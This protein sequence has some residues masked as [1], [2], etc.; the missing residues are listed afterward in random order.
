MFLKI[1]NIIKKT[2]RLLFREL[3]IDGPN[4][5]GHRR[6][7][8]YT[9]HLNARDKKNFWHS[10][11][12]GK[13]NYNKSNDHQNILL[14]AQPKSASLH[15]HAIIADA[16]QITKHEIGFNYY[17]G[18]LYYPR[19][20][21]AKYL[22]CDTISHC[23]AEPTPA[24]VDI[25][26]TLNLKVLVL[27]RNLA[28]TLISRLEMLERDKY[29]SEM[30]SA[31]AIQHFLTASDE[32]KR[33][34]IIDLFAAPYLNFYTGWKSFAAL[35]PSKVLFISYEEMK[36]DTQQLLK[37]VAAWCGKPF[38]CSSE[39]SKESDQK[40]LNFNKGI[41]GRGKM[42][43]SN[44]QKVKILNLA[45]TFELNDEKYIGLSL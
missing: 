7:W 43:F 20:L 2:K 41:I 16:L 32:Q 6:N 36:S 23:H 15:M 18:H 4:L 8:G 9:M 17:G 33:D 19:I 5:P 31:S 24:T 37:T 35:N 25:V 42:L 1:K 14:C 29:C 11:A 40:P 38:S 27:T 3:H 34:I 10:I 30:C 28:D 39:F 21:A 44:E 26:N 12:S 22:N 13:V 45:A